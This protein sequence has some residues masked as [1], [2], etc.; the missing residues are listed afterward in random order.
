VRF[1]SFILIVLLTFGVPLVWGNEQAKGL[2]FAQEIKRLEQVAACQPGLVTVSDSREQVI[3]NHCRT[4]THALKDFR[5]RWLSKAA[6]FFKAHV[7]SNISKTIVYPFGGADLVTLLTIFPAAE[8]FTSISLESSGDP[9]GLEDLSDEELG[10]EL[11]F[12]RAKQIQQLS[13][14]HSKTTNL[15]RLSRATMTAEQV[16]SLVALGVHGYEVVDLQFFH[17]EEDGTMRYLTQNDLD[18]ALKGLRPGT[19]DYEKRSRKVFANME[20]SFQYKSMGPAG[21]TKIYR[22]IKANLSNSEVEKNRGLQAYI[23]SQGRI[24][25]LFKAASFLIPQRAFSLIR[26]LILAQADWMVS[27]STGVL[28][29]QAHQHGF[30]IEAFGRYGGAYLKMGD[31]TNPTLV[32]FWASRKHK[33][34]NFR[35][36]YPDNS[37]NHHMLIYRKPIGP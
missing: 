11:E 2:S 16:F 13:F 30:T 20:I 3:R 33:A 8:V 28:P 14:S 26:D 6:P 36:G 12:L 23:Q 24:A 37:R 27:D 25:T 35:F 9:R 17:L 10:K 21:P 32:P 5:S 31:W 1:L 4:L 19:R 7:P 34:L 29:K 22:H 15:G 18:A